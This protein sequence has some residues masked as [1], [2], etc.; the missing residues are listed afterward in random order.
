M[1]SEPR[2]S[3]T[4]RAEQTI[5]IG[6]HSEQFIQIQARSE[7]NTP[8]TIH[9]GKMNSYNKAEMEQPTVVSK[10]PMY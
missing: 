2:V 10:L 1:V 5:N 3:S 7:D 4:S 8:N 6:T 9:Q